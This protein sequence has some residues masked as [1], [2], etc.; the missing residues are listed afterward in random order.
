MAYGSLS[1]AIWLPLG[2]HLNV[3][4]IVR[5]LL[6]LVLALLLN[7]CVVMDYLFECPECALAPDDN[8]LDSDSPDGLLVFGLTVDA[9]MTS[10]KPLTGDL[11]WLLETET[12]VIARSVD[13]PENLLPGQ[14]RLIVWQVPA[15]A[16]SLRHAH[17]GQSRGSRLSDI[18]AFN[19]A[20]TQVHAGHA[21][22]IG[23]IHVKESAGTP[24][25]SFSPETNFARKELKTYAKITAPIEENPL[26]DKRFPSSEKNRS[27]SH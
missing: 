27:S 5:L 20:T 7:S 23:E 22:I 10:G 15:G 8:A 25:L 16:W 4:D 17:L 13:F 24:I 26:G 19:S 18:L 2:T 14:H 12:D 21:T 6:S 1:A 3:G 11:G 9:T